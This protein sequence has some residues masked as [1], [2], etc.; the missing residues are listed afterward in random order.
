MT[1]TPF[2]RRAA[3]IVMLPFL[4][5][6]CHAGALAQDRS[7]GMRLDSDQPVQIEGDTLEVLEDQRRAV[8]NGN[9][10]VSQ[11]ETVL[12]TGRLVIHYGGGGSSGSITANGS[13]IERLEATGGVN[14]RSGAQVATGDTGVYDMRTE[15]LV[16]SGERVT[17]SENGNVATGC[18]LTLATN[19]GRATLTGCGSGSR[20][21]ILLQ[22][23]SGGGN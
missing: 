7:T 6:A 21:T 4:V 22:P 23:Q 19:T 8:F 1:L 5:L 14:I 16:L 11:G 9:V 20:P 17:L 10:R 2:M 18:K 12:R 3:A 15:V 13:Q